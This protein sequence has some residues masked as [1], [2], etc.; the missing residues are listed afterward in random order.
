MKIDWEFG[1]LLTVLCHFGQ[2]H[3]ASAAFN[4]S[5]KRGGPMSKQK[6]YAVAVGREPGVY[7]SW[8]E[9]EA[10]VSGEEKFQTSVR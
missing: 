5:M 8:P 1:V 3:F 6:V 9:C 2:L 4:L 10:Q 7:H